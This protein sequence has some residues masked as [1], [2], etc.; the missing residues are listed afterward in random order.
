MDIGDGSSAEKVDKF[1]YV[2]D[3]LSVD[4][5]ADAALTARIHSSRFKFRS[6]ASFLTAKDFP[7]CSEEKFM[8]L[9]YGVLCYTIARRGQ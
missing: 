6:L 3:M 2:G 7:C 5:D 8:M 9:V 4:G 1:C